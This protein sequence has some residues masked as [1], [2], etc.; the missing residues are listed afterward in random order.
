MRQPFLKSFALAG[1]TNLALHFGHRLSVDLD[2][3]TDQSFSEQDVFKE[4]LVDFPTTIKTDEAKNTLS[5]FIEGIKVD[6]LAHRY[7]LLSSFTQEAGVR[8]WSIEDIIA[9]KLGAVSGRG[10]KKDFW[11]IAKLLD[12][13]SLSQMLQFFAAKYANSDPGYV[14]RSLTYFEDAELQIDPIALN[15]I[16][17]PEV[18]DCV[19]RAVKELV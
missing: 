16:T 4:L 18:K 15:G 8:F 10:A 11:D 2:L 5:L 7:P 12:H 1:G 6:L 13:Y 19:L 17:W 9:M 14:V 3:F